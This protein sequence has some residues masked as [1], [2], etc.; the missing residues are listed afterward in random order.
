[1]RLAILYA[2]YY[3]HH[4]HS[5]LCAKHPSPCGCQAMCGSQG[6]YGHRKL[7]ITSTK[8]EREERREGKGER[9][10]EREIINL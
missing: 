6:Q 9:E 10:K 1:M 7:C 2:L 8:G 3:P 4:T 5:Q